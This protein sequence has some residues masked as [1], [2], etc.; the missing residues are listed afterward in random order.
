MASA[1]DWRRRRGPRTWLVLAALAAVL[2][3]VVFR[4]WTWWVT[5]D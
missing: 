4:L 1:M 2:V 3:Y 5:L